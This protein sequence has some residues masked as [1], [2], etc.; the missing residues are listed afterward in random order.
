MCSYFADL[1]IDNNYE[2]Q[3]K[4]EWVL[5]KELETIVKWHEL[6]GKYN[7]PKNDDYKHIFIIE[8]H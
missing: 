7:S 8:N 3:L 4:K 5:E 2:N 6:L 1:G